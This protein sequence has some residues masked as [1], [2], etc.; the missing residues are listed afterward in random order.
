MSIKAVVSGSS[1]REVDDVRVVEKDDVVEDELVIMILPKSTMNEIQEMADEIGAN[2]M[3]VI[4]V[5]LRNLKTKMEAS[6]D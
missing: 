2:P 4:N 6:D 5:A 3:G 1:R